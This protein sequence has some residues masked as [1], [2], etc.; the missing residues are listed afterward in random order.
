MFTDPIILHGIGYLGMLGVTTMVVVCVYHLVSRNRQESKR[1]GLRGLKRKIALTQHDGFVVFEPLMRFV[2]KCT[3]YLSL[4]VLRDRIEVLLRHSGYYLGL[5]V[6]EFLA[7][8]LLCA[9]AVGGVGALLVRLIGLP[10][11]FVAFFAGL[12][13]FLPYARVRGEIQQR[14]KEI[15]RSLP[16][17]IDLLS[18]CMGAGLDFPGAV[19]QLVERIAGRADALQEEF[20][21]ILQ[22]IQLGFTR[23]QALENFAERT[24][25]QSVQ[26]FVSS[27][28]QSEERG[29][30]LVEVL[31]IQANAARTRRS[32]R[33]EEMA[34]RA[35]VMMMGPLALIFISIMVLLLGPFAIGQSL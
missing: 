1:L 5:S 15:N 28:V 17:A 24:P 13:M 34:A 4:P 16:N 31:Q 26:E 18:L 21:W 22:E 3:A 12:G 9:S 20:Y 29:T 33:A 6:N 11:V 23:R 25:S 35:A 32:M 27:V 10:P 14:T 7:L 2:A 30:P 8:T 19:R